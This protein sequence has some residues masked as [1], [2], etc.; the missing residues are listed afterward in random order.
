LLTL[1]LYIISFF[2]VVNGSAAL[3]NTYWQILH[4]K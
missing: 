3:K 1:I 2:I 4:P